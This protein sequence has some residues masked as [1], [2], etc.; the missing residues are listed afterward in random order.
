MLHLQFNILI[1]LGGCSICLF[2]I[3]I[4]IIII[5]MY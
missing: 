1:W 4:I 2:I 3:I 5:I